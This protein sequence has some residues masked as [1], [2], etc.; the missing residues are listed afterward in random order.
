MEKIQARPTKLIVDLSAI[1][2]NIEQIQKHIGDDTKIMP[3]IKANAYG[4]GIEQVIKVI[5]KMKIDI[6]AVAI[7]D[8]GIYLRQIGYTGEIFVLNQPFEDEIDTILEYNLTIGV[9]AKSFLE[10]LGRKEKNVK[11]HIEIGTGMG[12]TGI[13]ACNTHTFIENVKKYSNIQVEGIYTHFSSSDSDEEYTKQQMKS[14]NEA[15]KV[16]KEELGDIKYI[17]ASNSAATI[18]YNEPAYNLVRPGI[19][20]YGHLPEEELSHKIDLKKSTKLQSV[21]SYIKEVNEGISIGYNRS[22][23]TKRK[24]KIATIPIGYADGVRRHL[25]NNGNIVINNKLAPI[26]GKVCMDSLMIDITEIE[27]VKIGTK[28]YIWD[29]DKITLEDV[30]NRCDTISYEI[31]STIS[32]RVVR[33]YVKSITQAN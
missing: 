12:R 5:E 17:H 31:L 24:T 23:I 20:L 21:V 30:A 33:E 16:V 18:K 11:I 19:I 15:I 28:V 29:N 32:P 1:E 8:E 25:S 2:Y 14:F 26:I 22:Y 4:L 10:Q 27:D 3:V 9:S 13:K 6:V 7:V